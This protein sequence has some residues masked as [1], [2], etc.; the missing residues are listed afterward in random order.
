MRRARNTAPP[1]RGLLLV[2]R[3]DAPSLSSAGRALRWPQFMLLVG[4]AIASAEERH[5]RHFPVLIKLIKSALFGPEE[6]EIIE[7][8]AVPLSKPEYEVFRLPGHDNVVVKVSPKMVNAEG[9]V[10]QEVEPVNLKAFGSV[11]GIES[12]DDTIAAVRKVDTLL[13]SGILYGGYDGLMKDHV[14]AMFPGIRTVEEEI[15]PV[16]ESRPVISEVIRPLEGIEFEVPYDP[17]S[18]EQLNNHEQATIITADT[19]PGTELVESIKKNELPYCIRRRIDAALL[20]GADPYRYERVEEVYTAPV[21]DIFYP[22]LGDPVIE[23]RFHEKILKGFETVAHKS[24]KLGVP[25]NSVHLEDVQVSFS[26]GDSDSKNDKLTAF[27]NVGKKVDLSQT[28]GPIPSWYLERMNITDNLKTNQLKP[29]VIA[30][31]KEKV[32]S[33]RVKNADHPE[34]SIKLLKSKMITPHPLRFHSLHPVKDNG[35]LDDQNVSPHTINVVKADQSP[36]YPYLKR[37]E[38]KAIVKNNNEPKPVI[39]APSKEHSLSQ[40]VKNVVVAQANS[41]T[42]IEESD[43]KAEQNTRLNENLPSRNVEIANVAEKLKTVHKKEGDQVKPIQVP[44]TSTSK[45]EATIT[46]GNDQG[47]V[48]VNH[49]NTMAIKQVEENDVLKTNVKTNNNKNLNVVESVKI[50]PIKISAAQ[51][52]E[53]KE[54][55]KA[56]ESKRVAVPVSIV[57]PLKRNDLKEKESFAHNPELILNNNKKDKENYHQKHFKLIEPHAKTYSY[58]QKQADGSSI[59]VEADNNGI[60]VDFKGRGDIPDK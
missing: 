26:K 19:K 46:D 27:T 7:E 13:S 39:I 1:P 9:V 10:Y 16:I 30:A 23:S 21:V 29:V 47:Y 8:V 55:K 32:V 2:G 49:P 24:Q 51:L 22:K 60:S 33:Q 3:Q 6:P 44:I 52:K 56:I 18:Y 36:T 54:D 31:P 48:Y 15:V 14:V 59:N 34:N 45:A 38:A 43:T 20:L 25:S 12:P 4:I 53:I 58:Q 17:V 40:Y 50:E 11:V 5:K 57:N 42:K 35:D 41:K 28:L 37:T